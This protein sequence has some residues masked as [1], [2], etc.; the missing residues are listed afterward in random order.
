MQSSQDD[1]QNSDHLLVNTLLDCQVSLSLS[2]NKGDEKNSVFCCCI[3]TI[4]FHCCIS[5][6]LSNFIVCVCSHMVSGRWKNTEHKI[7]SQ[8]HFSCV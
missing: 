5:T 4:V 6:I 8:F 1:F 2:T 7:D 3:I